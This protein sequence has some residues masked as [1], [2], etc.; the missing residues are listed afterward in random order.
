MLAS[1]GLRI[2]KALG[3]RLED[4]SKEHGC[5]TVR[6]SKSGRSAGRAGQFL[7]RP[8]LE[9]W[10][11]LRPKA[12]PTPFFFVNEFGGQL[13]RDP[14]G[15]QFQRYASLRAARATP[16]RASPCTRFATWPG[17]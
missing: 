16:C 11:R 4:Y 13:R 3:L 6:Q 17:R 5:L 9:D 1:T 15:H 8:M 10:L 2:S 12:S 7:A 14:W